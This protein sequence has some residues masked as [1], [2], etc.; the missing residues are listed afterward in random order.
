VRSR[1]LSKISHTLEKE[2]KFKS[3]EQEDKLVQAASGEL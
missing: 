3:V 1:Y 2:K